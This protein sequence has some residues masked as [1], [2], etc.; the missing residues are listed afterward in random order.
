M[1]AEEKRRGMETA[2]YYGNLQE[3]AERVKNKFLK[4]L[5]EAKENGKTVAGYGAA[6]K[7]NTLLNFAGV[8]PDLLAFVCDGAA[9]K[10]GKFLPGSHIPVLPPS[11]LEERRPDF[12]IIL[13]WNIA[14]E[15]RK[16]NT[17][18]AELGTEFVTFVPEV[19]IWSNR[20]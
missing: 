4:F 12:L 5:L 8:G 3:C 9:A 6:A 18:L 7:G 10:Q 20:P 14:D 11:T 17:H 1:L 16:Q 13:P 15:I 19:R 2:G